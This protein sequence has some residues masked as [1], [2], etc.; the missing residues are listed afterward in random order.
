MGVFFLKHIDKHK[1]PVFEWKISKCQT[2]SFKSC[3]F[4]YK[5]IWLNSYHNEVMFANKTFLHSRMGVWVNISLI[6]EFQP[7]DNKK[8]KK[9]LVWQLTLKDFYEN[10]SAHKRADFLDFI[11]LGN[12]HI[13][14]MSL[15]EARDQK[16]SKKIL[17]VFL[18][19]P[20]LLDLVASSQIALIP[21]VDWCPIS[22]YIKTIEKKRKE[23]S[24]VHIIALS[25]KIT[26]ANSEDK[27]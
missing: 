18:L 9:N 13:W 14:Q 16:C 27:P 12:C 11:L 24:M 5:K 20:L 25:H 7:L 22:S 21:L 3:L 10:K 15:R 2:T 17:K 26:I 19:S 4:G 1:N 23:T 8:N 6:G